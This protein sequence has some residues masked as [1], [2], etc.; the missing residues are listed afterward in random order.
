MMIFFKKIEEYLPYFLPLF[1]IFSRVSADL[2]VILVSLFY[3]TKSVIDKDFNWLHFSWIKFSFIFFL[4]LFFLNSFFSINPLD[5]I[6]YSISFIRWPIFASAL[7]LWIFKTENSLKKFFTSTLLLMMFFVIDL[8]YQYLINKHGIF[9]L[10]T[11]DHILRLT[12]PFSNNFIPGRFILIYFFLLLTL[13]FFINYLENKKIN[14]TYISLA[15]LIS[16]FT[17]FI[18][19]ERMSLLIFATSTI[20]FEIIMFFYN[21][22]NLLKILFL[23][24]LIVFFCFLFFFLDPHASYRAITSTIEQILNFWESDYGIV[25]ITSFNKFIQNNIFFGSGLHQFTLVE[26]IYGFNFMENTKIMHGHNLPLNLLVETGI[27]GL[28]LFY[29]IV[30]I[31][32]KTISIKL[33]NNFYLLLL[34]IN[35][36]YICFFPL[37]THF[38]FTHNW[39]N[40]SYWLIIG[41]VSSM[42]KIYGTNYRSK[43]NK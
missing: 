24:L 29:L 18:T 8:W 21:K 39:M 30:F 1:L 41:L 42:I 35:L 4:Y 5:S 15:L 12:V 25:F 14:L 37:H 32:L 26:P 11:N 9:G 10:S 7:Y 22:K 6:F 13:Y 3:I 40:A 17:I 36:I 33:K 28:I 27:V 38:S 23:N 2:I 16:F 31:L 20:I 43:K 34:L 19:G